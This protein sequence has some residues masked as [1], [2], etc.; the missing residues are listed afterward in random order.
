MATPTMSEDMRLGLIMGLAMQPLVI[1][2][3]VTDPIAD[4]YYRWC[5]PQ[6]RTFS[7]EYID[8]RVPQSVVTTSS[9]GMTAA[10]VIN[11]TEW[12][13]YRGL[14][15]CTN[16]RRVY[17]CRHQGRTSVGICMRMRQILYSSRCPKGGLV[18]RTAA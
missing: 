2:G 13:N 17:M 1:S 4:I 9:E 5:Q 6:G 7:A 18:R 16:Y 3:T 10:F 12:T 14:L 8:T 15:A 11:S